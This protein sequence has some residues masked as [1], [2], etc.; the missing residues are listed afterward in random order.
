MYL[1]LAVLTVV[2]LLTALNYGMKY[3]WVALGTMTTIWIFLIYY[4][5]KHEIKY[6]SLFTL[7]ISLILIVLLILFML[8]VRRLGI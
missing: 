3:F 1:I 6:F 5:K 4:P 2:V 7:L 8:F